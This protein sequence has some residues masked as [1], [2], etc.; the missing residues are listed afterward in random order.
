LVPR[1]S[2]YWLKEPGLWSATFST[3]ILPEEFET[4]TLDSA[5]LRLFAQVLNVEDTS[6]VLGSVRN[7]GVLV[8]MQTY[9][10]YFLAIAD[11]RGLGTEFSSTNLKARRIHST[12]G[13]EFDDCAAIDVSASAFQYLV[14]SK[15]DLHDIRALAE[16]QLIQNACGA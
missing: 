14:A 13:H 8:D 4:G 7:I 3:D 11:F 15:G 9:G 6:A 2:E 12:G 5:T 16:L 10:W 1:R